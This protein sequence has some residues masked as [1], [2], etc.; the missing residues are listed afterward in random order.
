MKAFAPLLLVV[1]AGC[2]VAPGGAVSRQYAPC[3]T[4]WANEGRIT[5]IQLEPGCRVNGVLL[6]GVWHVYLV[7]DSIQ[8]SVPDS[9]KLRDS[10]STGRGYLPP[11]PTRRT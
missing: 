8:L 3:V 7:P 1:F 2:S 5:A 6:N 9:L 11:H 4:D 10:D